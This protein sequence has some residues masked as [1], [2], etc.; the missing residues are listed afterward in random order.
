MNPLEKT[1]RS[2]LRNLKKS[3]VL[4]IPASSN[5]D[6]EALIDRVS[7]MEGVQVFDADTIIHEDHVRFAFFHAMR[8]FE[9]GNNI[10][11][12]LGLELLLRAAGTAQIEV[13]IQSAGVKEP[14]NI[15]IGALAKENSK[16]ELLKKL[17]ATERKWKQ[18]DEKA[19]A[20]VIRKMVAIQLES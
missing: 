14:K 6:K 10:A 17:D 16:T 9:D 13:A 8:S 19:L 5:L 15:V 3:D 20:E 7:K 1:S 11:R 18:K 2:L 12:S 4:V